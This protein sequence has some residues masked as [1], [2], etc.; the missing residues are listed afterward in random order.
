MYVSSCVCVCCVLWQS[1][2]ALTC[3]I[4]NVFLLIICVY[5][6]PYLFQHF[7]LCIPRQFLCCRKTVNYV[8]H[9]FCFRI[10]FVFVIFYIIA[11]LFYWL[12]C[13]RC[14]S[15]FIYLVV[16]GFFVALSFTFAGICCCYSCY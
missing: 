5:A 8:C 10:Q 15:N 6:F 12:I 7:A 16:P 14:V 4:H 11:A 2:A 9:C 1:I 3:A 13:Y